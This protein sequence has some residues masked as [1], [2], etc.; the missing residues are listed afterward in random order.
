MSFNDIDTAKSYATEANLIKALEK[1]GF[2]DKRPMVVRN[3]AGRYTAIFSLSHSG[4]DGGYIAVFASAGF[5]TY[6]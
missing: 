1:L 4:I 3:R 6:P 5:K 2:A